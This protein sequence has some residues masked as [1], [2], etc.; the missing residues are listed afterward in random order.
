M[1]MFIDARQEHFGRSKTMLAPKQHAASEQL[2]AVDA[3]LAWHDGDARATIETLLQDCGHLRSQLAV[4][5]SFL[6]RGITRG[7]IPKPE[8]DATSW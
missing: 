6:S 7:W 3:A 8:R 4:A 2:D 1:S 5:N